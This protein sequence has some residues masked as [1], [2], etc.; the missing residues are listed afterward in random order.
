MLYTGLCP[1]ELTHQGSFLLLRP[2]ILPKA[3]SK[4]LKATFPSR[5][6]FL[7]QGQGSQK[8]MKQPNRKMSLQDLREKLLLP[9]TPPTAAPGPVSKLGAQPLVSGIWVQILAPPFT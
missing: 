9:L 7:R 6:P 2:L 4:A 3:L 1:Q 8:E 5:Q